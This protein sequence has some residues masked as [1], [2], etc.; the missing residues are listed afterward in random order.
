M[1]RHDI[2]VDQGIPSLNKPL[3]ELRRFVIDPAGRPP[4]VFSY[5]SDAPFQQ[6]V[7]ARAMGMRHAPSPSFLLLK[8]AFAYSRVVV[9]EDA[10]IVMPKPI[11]IAP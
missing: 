11:M 9:R 8:N 3:Q 4:M 2:K 1:A 10:R 6:L 5:H 7:V